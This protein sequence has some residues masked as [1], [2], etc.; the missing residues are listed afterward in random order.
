MKLHIHTDIACA[1]WRKAFPRLKEKMEQAAS[2][3]FLKA[4]KP[5]AF[6]KRHFD[7]GLILTN[8]RTVKT[9]NR[10]Y[11]GQDKPTNVLSFPQFDF[12]NFSRQ[13]L[14]SFPARGSPY[15]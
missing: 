8:D 14:D 10:D 12:S 15:S 13:A 5:V 7:I 1:R 9:L 3:A 4:K 11:R 6:K 2:L